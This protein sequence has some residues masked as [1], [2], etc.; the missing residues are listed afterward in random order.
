MLHHTRQE[1]KKLSATA[2]LE[3][4]FRKVIRKPKPTKIMIDTW[5]YLAAKMDGALA[6]QTFDIML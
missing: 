3:Y 4:R 1:V 5:M 6:I 2:L